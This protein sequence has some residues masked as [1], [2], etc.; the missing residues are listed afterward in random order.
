MTINEVIAVFFL[1]K[2]II[3]VEILT[4]FWTEFH[5]QNGVVHPWILSIPQEV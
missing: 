5:K 1:L 3:E 2:S 4:I